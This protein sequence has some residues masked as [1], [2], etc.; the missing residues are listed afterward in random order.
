[1][2]KIEP[3][4][5]AW[6]FKSRNGNRSNGTH[7]NGDGGNGHNGNGLKQNRGTGQAF[8]SWPEDNRT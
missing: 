4:R 5:L 8:R 2:E 1:M 3:V 6:P 7:R